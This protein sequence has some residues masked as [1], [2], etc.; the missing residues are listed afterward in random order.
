VP[1]VGDVA[2]RHGKS[3]HV[4]AR[5]YALE[6]TTAL[7][8]SPVAVEMSLARIAAKRLPAQLPVASP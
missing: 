3:S 8:R 1:G 2:Y 5:G 6:L 4:H 7:V